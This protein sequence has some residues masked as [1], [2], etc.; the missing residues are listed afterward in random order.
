[1]WFQYQ[2]FVAL[3]AAR[4]LSPLTDHNFCI[5]VTSLNDF[6]PLK[7]F[8]DGFVMSSSSAVSKRDSCKSGFERTK[9]L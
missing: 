4:P 3:L 7:I 2:F 1:M 9:I 8:I 6:L 5:S